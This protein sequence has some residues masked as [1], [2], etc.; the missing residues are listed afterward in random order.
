MRLHTRDYRRRRGEGVEPSGERNTRQAGFEDRWGHRAP[1]SSKPYFLSTFGDRLNRFAGAPTIIIERR[2]RP[3]RRCPPPHG[4]CWWQ[5][6][7]AAN[8][9]EIGSPIVV[10]RFIVGPTLTGLLLIVYGIGL[11]RSLMRPWTRVALRVAGS[12]V[13]A[14]GVLVLTLK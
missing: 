11:V 8:G 3:A 2:A 7:L 4:R 5:K 1:S 13:V 6:F 10:Y 12:W 14:I 9:G